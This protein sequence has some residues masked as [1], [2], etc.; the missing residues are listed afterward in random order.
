VLEAH[1]E[2]ASALLLAGRAAA[3]AYS[4]PHAPM[5]SSIGGSTWSSN[6]DGSA[7]ALSP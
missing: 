4:P 5:R 6:G 1:R 2:A 7:R 3:I